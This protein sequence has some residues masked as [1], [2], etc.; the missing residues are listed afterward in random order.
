MAKVTKESLF[1]PKLTAGETKSEAIDRAARSIIDQ[2]IAARDAKTAR[3]RLARL[4]REAE[5]RARAS[6]PQPGRLARK[7]I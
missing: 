5:E 4:A 1:K 3:L 6:A 7:R 2:Q